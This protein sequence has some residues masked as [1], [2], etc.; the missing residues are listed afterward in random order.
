MHH[1][2]LIFRTIIYLVYL[3]CHTKQED[4]LFF[5]A[6]FVNFFETLL[7]NL[8]YLTVLYFKN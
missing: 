1:F 2:Q 8:G 7:G 3:L 5:F 6:L 4:E